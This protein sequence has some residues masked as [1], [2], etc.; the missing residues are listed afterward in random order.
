V[1]ST[2]RPE[3]STPPTA[4]KPTPTPKPEKPAASTPAPPPTTPTRRT[5]KPKNTPVPSTSETTP[6]APPPADADADAKEQYRFETAK[7]KAIQDPQVKAL[8][9][10]ADLA[11]TEDESRAALRAYN[12]ALFQKIRKIDPGVSEYADPLEKAILK[13]LGE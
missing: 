7:S 1:E 8:K 4:E 9:D 12:K 5:P 10:K 2:P 3:K 13:R 6:P 11:Q